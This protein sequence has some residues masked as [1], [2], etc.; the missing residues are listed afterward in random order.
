MKKTS[1]KLAR[2]KPAGLRFPLPD[3]GHATIS[4]PEAAAIT[5]SSARTVNRWRQTGVIPAACL[6][7]LQHHHAGHIMPAEWRALGARFDGVELQVGAYRFGR[8][9]L[10]GY[11][12]MLQ[13]LMELRRDRDR[14]PGEQ[15]PLLLVLEGGRS[16]A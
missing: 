7:L 1:K 12:V 2:F 3:G 16:R 4:V 13:A 5:D 10:E 8:G 6:R 15:R 9:E 14:P 11:G